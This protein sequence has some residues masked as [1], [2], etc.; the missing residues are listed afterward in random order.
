M[1]TCIHGNG[2]YRCG[3][4]NRNI[5]AV[6]CANDLQIICSRILSDWTESQ[7][8]YGLREAVDKLRAALSD[9]PKPESAGLNTPQDSK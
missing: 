1:N 2:L 4:C 8:V 7:D 9:T 6:E 5:E 3:I